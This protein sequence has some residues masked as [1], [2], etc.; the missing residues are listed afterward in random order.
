MGKEEKISFRHLIKRDIPLLNEIRNE[1]AKE[2]LHDSRTFT[3]EESVEWFEKTKPDFW[4]IELNSKMIGYFRLSN[5][6]EANHN[7]YVGADLH[8]EHRGRGFAYQAYIQFIPFLFKEYD[9]HKIS[10]E[11]LA[12]NERAFNLYKKI[13]FKVEGI[14]REEVLKEGQY[15]NSIVMSILKNEWKDK[16]GGK[17]NDRTI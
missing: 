15:I 2:Y 9:L 12:T 1:C 6:S 13:G 11:V 14:K 16:K 5:Y 7:L 17:N 10:L 4:A 8:K 3:V